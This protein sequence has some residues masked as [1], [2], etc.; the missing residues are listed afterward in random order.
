MRHILF[1][2]KIED[3]VIKKD[4]SLLLATVMKERGIECYLLFKDDFFYKNSSQLEVGV[5]D[6]QGQR[7]NK[8]NYLKS[9]EIKAKRKIT[10]G[11]GDI[12][13][14]RIDPPF[15]SRYLRYL[16]MLQ[17]MEKH[18]VEVINS[19]Q[20]IMNHNEKL[21]AYSRENSIPSYV[22]ESV[23]AARDFIND[24]DADIEWLILKPL[25]LFQGIGVEKLKR[26]DP[27]FEKIFQDRVEKYK[28]PIIV[29][30]FLS[31]VKDGEVRTLYYKGLELGTILKVPPANGFL[32]NIASGA[33]YKKWSLSEK[34]KL[35]CDQISK[36]LMEV[37][38]DWIAFDVL[39]DYV[40]EVNI[41]CP[42]LLVEVAEAC[43]N[44]LVNRLIDLMISKNP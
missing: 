43:Q 18:G 33:S 6:F 37:G 40:S 34:Q 44:N 7:L 32:A 15:D 29:Q 20:G 24:L 2:D 5:Y 36:E 8:G 4:S 23:S 12:V 11:G 13:H 22:G 19:P 21:Y 17:G 39:G 1:I 27:G 35:E 14:M 3:L 26:V 10:L 30:P 41:T 16:W 28:G 42:G 31:S 38:V 9:F 25:D